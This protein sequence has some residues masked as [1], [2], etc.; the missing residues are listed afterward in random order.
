MAKVTKQVTDTESEVEEV[1]PVV[2][3]TAV[4][5]NIPSPELPVSVQV[6]PESVSVPKDLLD[7]LIDRLDNQE[8][9]IK[10]LR[11]A[12][13]QGK[14]SEAEAQNRPD[15]LPKAYL[16]VLMGKVVV[17]WRTFKAE[18]YNHP[19]NPSVPI[20]EV[21]KSVYIFL[22]GTESDPIDQVVFTRTDDKVFVRLLD[23]KDALSGSSVGTVRV[24][25]ESLETT[26]EELR[27]TFVIPEGEFEV[28][29][30]SL[31]P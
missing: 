11:Q 3:G 5:E 14:L 1:V 15:E 18:L 2:D 27:S 21:L 23:G 31:N 9:D 10:I 13:S 28:K 24:R 12:A 6:A 22:D 20:G 17:G 8:K 19:T 16:K 7:R 29:K 4:D 25:F 30:S 26:D